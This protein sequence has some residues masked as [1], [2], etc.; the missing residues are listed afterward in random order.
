MDARRPFAVSYPIRV[1]RCHVSVTSGVF[2]FLTCNCSVV[3]LGLSTTRSVTAGSPLP[4]I[5][6][7][8]TVDARVLTLVENEGKGELFSFSSQGH[9]LSLDS[10]IM[11]ETPTVSSQ[12]SVNRLQSGFDT[13]GFLMTFFFN[14]FALGFTSDCFS[15]TL[16]EGT[17]PEGAFA[18]EDVDLWNLSSFSPSSTVGAD[19][20]E[21]DRGFD[22]CRLSARPGVET[23]PGVFEQVDAVAVTVPCFRAGVG[24]S[25]A[26]PRGLILG[27]LPCIP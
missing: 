15:G 12:I 22:G 19:G 11:G 17:K 20:A 23:D 16:V 7:V 26:A 18:V 5:F 2:G 13:T 27:S 3:S 6:D 1:R 14:P 10:F 8:G 24:L 4:S 25:W 9:L 21:R